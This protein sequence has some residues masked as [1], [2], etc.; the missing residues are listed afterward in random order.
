MY[1]LLLVYERLD[2]QGDLV[3][4]VPGCLT[5]QGEG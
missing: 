5:A 1:S 4:P 2:R 3:Q